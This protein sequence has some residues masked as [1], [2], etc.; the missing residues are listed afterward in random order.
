[1]KKLF[2]L[3]ITGSIALGAT[4]QY[5]QTTAVGISAE[6]NQ[7]HGKVY[8][9]AQMQAV[10]QELND[11]HNPAHKT[12][13]GGSRWYNFP[14]QYVD[15]TQKIA[16]GG[17]D[18]IG[19]T[20]VSNWRD[21]NLIGQFSATVARHVSLLTMAEI[22][23]PAAASFNDSVLFT[24]KM[25][26]T[27]GNS[28]TVDS[29]VV[30]GKYLGNPAKSSLI[31]TLRLSFVTGHGGSPSSDDIWGGGSF[32]GATGHYA[33]VNFDEMH[34][35]SVKNYA[36]HGTA[37][38]TPST[39][40]YDILL[41]SADWAD[42]LANGMW[43]KAIQLATP[44]SITAGGM[45]GMSITFIT[46]DVTAPTTLVP[47]DTLF[48][49]NGTYKYNV[50]EPAVAFVTTTSAADWAPYIPGDNNVG[51]YKQ[52]PTWQGGWSGQFYP[53]WGYELV[54]GGAYYLQY[55]DISWHVTC[56]SCGVLTNMVNGVKDV[57]GITNVVVSP[58]PANDVVNVPFT[59]SQ[60]AHVTVSLTN[61]IGQ[62]VASQDMGNVASG[63]AV[64]NTATLPQ[65]IYVYTVN[66]NNERSTGRVVVAH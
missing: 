26:L 63:K 4:A 28:Y 47:G 30:S 20:S 42:T 19:W 2:L 45:A 43:S 37:Y 24:G 33:T 7:P 61:M 35:D 52:Q 44:L 6:L 41:T 13:S 51:Y 32:A 17:A 31:D 5:R 57:T 34:Y 14:Y 27:S 18:Y 39:N 59:L 62:V 66:A 53:Q 58:N 29:V 10:H 56:A 60:S 40:V 11:S 38:G 16:S 54:G 12:T 23:N 36:R 50:F 9:K 21:T 64:F 25:K 1:M 65:G 55:P 46:S 48:R 49:A 22:F 8:T 15:T 3:L